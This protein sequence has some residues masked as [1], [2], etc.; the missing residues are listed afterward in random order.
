MTPGSFCDPNGHKVKGNRTPFRYAL[1]RADRRQHGPPSLIP[2]LSR[3]LLLA[4]YWRWKSSG[5]S[6][7]K[8]VLKTK[9]VQAQSGSEITCLLQNDL[10]LG[11]KTGAFQRVS[12]LAGHAQLH[13]PSRIGAATSPTILSAQEQMRSHVPGTSL[14]IS[15]QSTPNLRNEADTPCLK[16]TR[17]T[18]FGGFDECGNYRNLL[19]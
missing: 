10:S 9:I 18:G 2:K 3:F 8:T 13:R 12:S 11:T 19:W 14:M 1:H 6:L 4:S 16:T 17:I 7:A 15:N 5:K